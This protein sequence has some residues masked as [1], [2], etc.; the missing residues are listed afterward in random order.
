MKNPTLYEYKI[1]DYQYSV[2]LEYKRK[3]ELREKKITNYEEKSFLPVFAVIY[4]LL[5]TVF[6]FY[7]SWEEVNNGNAW[8]FIKTIWGVILASVSIL[9]ILLIPVIQ[10]VFCILAY[11]ICFIGRCI[12]K[13]ILIKPQKEPYFSII[14]KYEHKQKE[15]TDYI[16]NLETKYPCIAE[17]NYD[18]K[19][20][21][22][23]I[24]ADIIEH[25]K[26]I[27]MK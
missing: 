12:Y 14:E 13:F 3:C 22:K 7:Y 27:L 6:V 21:F 18:K 20:Y 24:M 1:T 23:N 25:E 10:W 4:L 11:P 26:N 15:Y 19:M 5:I 9:P 2:Y 8:D 17:F 16:K